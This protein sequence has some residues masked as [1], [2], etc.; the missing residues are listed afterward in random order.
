MVLLAFRLIVRVKVRF[1]FYVYYVST[2]PTS[3]SSCV[4]VTL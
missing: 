3:F 1:T 4:I 2:K